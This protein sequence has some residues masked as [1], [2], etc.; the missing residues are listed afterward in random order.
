MIEHGVFFASGHKGEASQIGEHGP[1][2]ILSIKPQ[3][4]AL[5]RKLVRR[6]VSRDGR[7]CLPQFLSVASVASV[8]KTAEPL[9]AVGLTDDRAGTH[10]LPALAPPIARSTDVIQPAKRRGSS[11]VW[12]KAR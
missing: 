12:G 7:E 2:A 9:E 5:R 1:G 10:H 4:G 3:Q 8:A 11:S 6:E